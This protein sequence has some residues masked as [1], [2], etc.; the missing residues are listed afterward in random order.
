MD[1]YF[2]LDVILN[3][4]IYDRHNQ[5]FKEIFKNFIK[6]RFWFELFLAIPFWEFNLPKYLFY[7]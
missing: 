6:I 2:I 7:F 3:F 5:S 4:F 1:I